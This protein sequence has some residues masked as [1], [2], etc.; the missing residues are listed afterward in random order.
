VWFVEHLF[1]TTGVLAGR[2]PV[3]ARFELWVADWLES[4]G[5][6]DHE[7]LLRRFV[8]WEVLRPL[9]AASAR[10]GLSDYQHN[11][12]KVRLKAAQAFLGFLAGRDR[13]LGEC[14]QADLDAWGG[15]QSTN[16]CKAARPF[17]S[18]A[19]AQGL[20]P[21]LTYPPRI[22]ARD[23]NVVFGDG[24]WTLARHLLHADGVDP[25][26]RIAG[27]LVLLYAQVPSRICRLTADDVTST[28]A[29]VSLRLG[30]TPLRL[31]P[32]MAEYLRALLVKRPQTSAGKIAGETQWLFPGHHPGRPTNAMALAKRLRTIGVHPATDRPAALAHLAASMPP[33]IIADLLGVSPKTAVVW[34]EAAARTRAV[35]VAH[36]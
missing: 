14:T 36:R 11:A 9:R 21:A 31:P 34:S 17:S 3:L 12:A 5:V 24:E 18:W 4:V 26:D 1:T 13:P 6:A 2:D 27:L 23:R 22:D 28:D 20:S 8:I 30:A 10:R 32:P 16:R 25:H 7:R 33:V 29:G 15:S 35:Y 19:V